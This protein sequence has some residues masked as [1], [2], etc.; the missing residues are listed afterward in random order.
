MMRGTGI[1][2]R[3]GR[4]GVVGESGGGSSALRV[5]RRSAEERGAGK[6]RPTTR[7]YWPPG[8]RVT[9]VG[10]GRGR[11][12][13]RE[14]RSAWSSEKGRCEYSTVEVVETS[15]PVGEGDR[16]ILVKVE[17]RWWGDPSGRGGVWCGASENISSLTRQRIIGSHQ[18]L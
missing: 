13:K 10:A 2:P 7:L 6:V 18:P 14:G 5:M 11:V 1:G 15:E 17:V 4:R 9:V 8:S 12:E 3:C 16:D